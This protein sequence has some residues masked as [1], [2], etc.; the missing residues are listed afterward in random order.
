M[1]VYVRYHDAVLQV[2]RDFLEKKW[3]EQMEELNS[4]TNPKIE[5]RRNPI[6]VKRAV[7]KK[8]NNYV[9]GKGQSQDEHRTCLAG[10]SNATEENQNADRNENHF[11]KSQ[12]GN[13][14]EQGGE[15]RQ[16]IENKQNKKY[17]QIHM[18]EVRGEGLVAELKKE[19]MQEDNERMEP[20]IKRKNSRYLER[21]SDKA[22]QDSRAGNI[23][24][25]KSAELDKVIGGF[26]QHSKTENERD[27]TEEEEVFIRKKKQRQYDEES[28]IRDV[29]SDKRSVLMGTAE[30]MQYW[31]RIDEEAEQMALRD[32]MSLMKLK[33]LPLENDYTQVKER[34]SQISDQEGTIIERVEGGFLVDDR[35][36]KKPEYPEE[37]NRQETPSAERNL[38][39]N[40]NIIQVSRN[41]KLN[42]IHQKL[43]EKVKKQIKRSV[44]RIQREVDHSDQPRNPNKHLSDTHNN[45]INPRDPIREVELDY[46]KDE[47]TSERPFQSDELNTE[48]QSNDANFY[49]MMIPNLIMT[50]EQD[51]HKDLK[52]GSDRMSQ[53]KFSAYLKLMGVKT[54]RE[55]GEDDYSQIQKYENG[56]RHEQ[57]PKH[58]NGHQGAQSPPCPQNQNKIPNNGQEKNSQHPQHAK[59]RDRQSD[60]FQVVQIKRK[61]GRKGNGRLAN[62]PPK[63][64]LLDMAP[65]ESEID[66]I[67]RRVNDHQENR[68]ERDK[69]F[70]KRDLERK[71]G[72]MKRAEIN[73]QREKARDI[74]MLNHK[75]HKK[76]TAEK[77]QNGV[78]VGMNGKRVHNKP[79]KQ[80]NDIYQSLQSPQKQRNNN[81][82]HNNEFIHEEDLHRNRGDPV[83]ANPRRPTNKRAGTRKKSA[84]PRHS[85]GYQPFV[86]NIKDFDFQERKKEK[87]L[88]KQRNLR[89][90]NKKLHNEHLMK[91]K[92]RRSPEGEVDKLRTQGK[93]KGE[94]SQQMK[95]REG[96]EEGRQERA[97]NERQCERVFQRGNQWREGILRNPFDDEDEEE[98]QEHQTPDQQR[99]FANRTPNPRNTS[100][101]NQDLKTAENEKLGGNQ[102]NNK[103]TLKSISQFSDFLKRF[104]LIEEQESKKDN[105]GQRQEIVAPTPTPA[106]EHTPYYNEF[107]NSNQQRN[108][109]THNDPRYQTQ[110]AHP[111]HRFEPPSIHPPANVSSNDPDQIPTDRQS[112]PPVFTRKPCLSRPDLAYLTS[113]FGQRNQK[114]PSRH[115]FTSEHNLSVQMSRHQQVH[116][117][118]QG[119]GVL[120]T[121]LDLQG[122]KS[123]FNHS[124]R[125]NAHN[126]VYQRPQHSNFNKLNKTSTLQ[127]E[128]LLG[129]DKHGS[130]GSPSKLKNQTGLIRNYYDEGEEEEEDLDD[131]RFL[132]SGL[133]K[134][135]SQLE[136]KRPVKRRNN[137]NSEFSKI[138]QDQRRPTPDYQSLNLGGQ[139]FKIPGQRSKANQ[140]SPDLRPSYQQIPNLSYSQNMA[141]QE[142]EWKK[143]ALIEQ[144][145]GNIGRAAISRVLT[146]TMR[147][148]RRKEQL[149]SYDLRR[150]E[151]AV[152]K[153][154]A[155]DKRLLPTLYQ[156]IDVEIAIRSS[157]GSR[158]N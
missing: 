107:L 8:R 108:Q 9:I 142:L 31:R 124:N 34:Q 27:Q 49:D 84:K 55:I 6:I 56:K 10:Q 69:S 128:H 123:Q 139:H 90:I 19:I 41:T 116:P 22:N 48:N 146:E 145:S 58:R 155:L 73:M 4:R 17:Q 138:G 40:K 11:Q 100:P 157:V 3:S 20:V 35:Q 13:F 104:N 21:E 135:V 33:E 152:G 101:I 62:E 122:N 38:R 91:D 50:E 15:S 95:I 89:K 118:S 57:H 144:L 111:N 112:Q 39:Q 81:N 127:R 60:E 113:G 23:Q 96:G 37:D 30:E 126:N 77:V 115:T 14:Q 131:T 26:K 29:K 129:Q 154:G 5:G 86:R 153:R 2:M 148:F 12:S 51:K 109:T 68:K 88:E 46:H 59:N 64:S 82:Q 137:R 63:M 65:R 70:Q 110:D 18:K 94:D 66:R 44:H 61:V 106:S 130:P 121:S 79:Q 114:P 83:P 25:R 87:K 78:F 43:S 45:R 125:G 134:S 32:A 72:A 53:G 42:L 117:H 149:D 136:K 120:R 7:K 93:G 75:K 98:E 71:F 150:I 52:T 85:K 119:M 132:R 105:S 147:W 54:K 28:Q 143:H 74:E 67:G 1:D 140:D 47:R 80:R 92:R 158:A 151:A 97:D 24:V 76:A 102:R 16:G 36:K 99:H 156:L 103:G 141:G 133:P